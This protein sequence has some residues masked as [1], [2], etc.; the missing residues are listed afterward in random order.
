MA[1]GRQAGW[2]PGA[3]HEMGHLVVLERFDPQLW[4]RIGV[5][6][7]NPVGWRVEPLCQG[8]NKCLRVDLR[9]S[10]LC[11]WLNHPLLEQGWQVLKAL[12]C[13]LDDA[14]WG[15]GGLST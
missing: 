14:A 13:T 12:A 4:L 6:K 9:V 7:L 11:I 8:F 15:G 10:L 1:L 5:R 3:F 2:R